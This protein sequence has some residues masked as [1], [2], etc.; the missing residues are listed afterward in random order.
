MTTLFFIAPK[1]HKH[2]AVSVAH[3]KKITRAMKKS[4][5]LP[6]L[7]LAGL[8]AAQIP[9]NRSPLRIETIMQ[10]E[11]FAGFSP[12]DFSWSEDGKTIYFTWNPEL[13][14][15]RSLY[16]TDLNGSAPQRV[17]I[18]EQQNMVSGGAYSRDRSRKVYSKNGDIFLWE[19]ATGSSRPLIQ[20]T[21]SEFAPRFSGDERQV[22]Y[23]SGDNLFSWDMSTGA[24]RQLTNFQRGAKREDPRKSSQEQ[25][26]ETDQLA[27]FDVLRERKAESET[28]ERRT[29][30]L[31]PKRPFEYYYGE[32]S[33]SNLQI[34]PDLRF[35]TFRLTTRAKTRTAQ[36]PDYVTQSGFSSMQ[37]T[38]TKVGAAQD[39]HET[40]IFDA[41]RDTIYW[42]NTKNIEGIFDKPE[43]LRDYHRDT[44]PYNNKYD[45]PREIIM[46]GPVFSDDGKAAV[47]LRSQD[48]KDRWIMLLDL[49]TG[50]L[51][52]LDRQR[53]EAW[54]GGPGM[55]GEPATSAGCPTT[56]AS[57]SSLKPP[58]FHTFI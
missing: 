24:I 40:G 18:E 5:L 23:Q 37:D 43:F 9:A 26:L 56:A 12:D 2:P 6:L 41:Q 27:L 38:R 52:L 34:S 13:D 53:D 29:K 47:V 30:A 48:N 58:V 50:Q 44:L 20:T 57:G 35:V 39:T 28:R 17:S 46:H 4:L 15:L 49:P 1:G 3:S 54:I 33:L 21:A 7:F 22:V 45:K 36:M 25:W 16:K 10:G 55:G 8:A 42:L 11:R 14:T 31:A 32:R 51:R 19:A